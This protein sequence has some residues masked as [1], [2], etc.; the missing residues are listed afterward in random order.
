M[1]HDSISLTESSVY[2]SV[3]S[4]AYLRQSIASKLI[5]LYTSMATASTSS[6]EKST[7]DTDESSGYELAT[8]V[9]YLSSIAALF[10]ASFA[11]TSLLRTATP[12]EILMTIIVFEGLLLLALGGYH[13]LDELV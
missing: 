4:H 3:R 9:Q 7:N 12:I 10:G 5:H 6:D 13:I 1:S 11:I 2:C 8:V